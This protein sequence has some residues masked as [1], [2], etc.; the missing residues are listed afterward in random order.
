MLARPG[1]IISALLS[2][3]NTIPK[4]IPVLLKDR[5]KRWWIFVPAIAILAV[6]GGL[7]YYYQVIFLPSQTTTQQTLQ[8]TVARRGSIV[9]S[10]AGTGTLR[11]ANQ[12]SLAF[13]TGGRVTNLYVKVGDHVTAGQLLAELDNTAQKLQVEQAQQNLDSLTSTTALGNAQKALATADQGL[14]T[15]QLT[16]AYLISPDVYYWESQIDKDNQAIKDA[17]AAANANPTDQA[18]LARLKKATDL[19]SFE[20]SQLDDAKQNY[21]DYVLDTFTVKTTN[22]KTH[23]VV[24]TIDYPTPQDILKAR[25]GITIAQGALDDAQNLYAALTAG[26]VPSSAS[27]SGMVALDQARLDLIAA[28]DNLKATQLFAPFS[29]TVVAVGA[30]LGGQVGGSFTAPTPVGGISISTPIPKTAVVTIADLSTLY[31]ETYVDESDYAL[32][33]IGNPAT[34]VFD[35]LPDQTLTGKVAEV[36]PALNTSSGSAVVSGLVQLDPTSAPLLLGM[37]GSVTVISAQTQNAVLVPLAA[38]HEY[39]PGKYAV[40][41]MRNGKLSVQLV[42][43]GLRDLVNAEIKSGLQAGDIVSTGL[44]ATK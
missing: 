7:V 31:L 35:A 24:T 32:F 12:S 39:S 30:G 1:K 36:D 13:K 6:A 28:Q 40:L 16:L 41:V 4:Q 23:V 10:A 5:K 18:A 44:L 20:Q 37:G 14:R 19:L 29:G 3:L 34:I 11:A 42:Q 22:P 21:H 15:A 17:Q 33:K 27:G 43:V 2:K 8:T 25:Q 38:L 9:L 26:S